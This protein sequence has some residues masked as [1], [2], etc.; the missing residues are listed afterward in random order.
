MKQQNIAHDSTERFVPAQYI[1]KDGAVETFPNYMVS[2]RGRVGSL[3]NHCGNKRSVMKILKPAAPNKLGY[4][5]V[6]LRANGK[7]YQRAVHRLVLSSFHPE[8]WTRDKNEVDHIDRCPTNNL[9]GN[10]RWTDRNGNCTN[11]DTVKKIKV[12]YLC[13][14]HTEEFDNMR[15]CDRAFGKGRTW[16]VCIINNCKGFSKKYN[17]LIQKI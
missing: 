7:R 10:L 17:V 4:L 16:S 3:V 1:R 6:T 12:T 14:G 8:L 13:D 11:R 9:L 15:E 2:D 5:A